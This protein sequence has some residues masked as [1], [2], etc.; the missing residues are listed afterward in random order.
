MRSLPPALVADIRHAFFACSRQHAAS[1]RA[2]FTTFK[3]RLEGSEPRK[4]ENLPIQVVHNRLQ[5]QKKDNARPS[6]PSATPSAAGRELITRPDEAKSLDNGRKI[7][8]PLKVIPKADI[9]PGLTL[10]PKERLHIEQLTRR[11]PPR[12]E[13]KGSPCHYSLA[14]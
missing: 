1:R 2:R 10:S 5:A 11:L 7:Q 8:V 9:A 3:P 14:H 4:N 12:L 6:E 13:P